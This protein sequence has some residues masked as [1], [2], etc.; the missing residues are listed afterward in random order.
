VSLIRN[1]DFSQGLEANWDAGDGKLLKAKPIAIEAGPYT[2]GLRL[3]CDCGW[4]RAAWRLAAV[5][6]RAAPGVRPTAKR[7]PA[8]PR[9]AL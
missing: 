7:R 3:E 8:G 1:G 9:G 6:P 5:H 2:R 4:G